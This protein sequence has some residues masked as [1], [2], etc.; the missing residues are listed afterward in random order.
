MNKNAQREAVGRVLDRLTNSAFDFKEKNGVHKVNWQNY[1]FEV[2]E[3]GA[4]DIFM[5]NKQHK[6]SPVAASI[7]DD[8][9]YL[10]N[11]GRSATLEKEFEMMSDF[12]NKRFVGTGMVK[13]IVFD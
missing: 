3:Q 1:I 4:I 8:V 2:D 11:D 12:I 7:I 9:A 13:E 5:L 10:G 6:L